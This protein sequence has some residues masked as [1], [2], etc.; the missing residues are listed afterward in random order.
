MIG[1]TFVPDSAGRVS[2]QVVGPVST[3]TGSLN[4][5]RSFHTA[6]LLPNRK[7]LV[8][9]GIRYADPWTLT[10]SAEIYDP[11]TGMWSETGSLNA[12]RYENT[13]TLLADGKVLV[14]GGV[15]RASILGESRSL[16]SA[17][18]YDSLTGTWSSTGNLN[19]ARHGHAAVLL[20][21]GKILVA[22]GYNEVRQAGLSA[23]I[24]DPLTGRWSETGA[25]N[26]LRGVYTATLLAE[27]KVLVTG[28]INDD[29]PLS[30]ELYDPIGGTWSNTGDLKMVR[31]GH[32]SALLSSGKLLV[33]D[34]DNA[35]L[36]DPVTGTWSITGNLNLPYN[37]GSYT[38]TL[39]SSGKVLAVGFFDYD[40]GYYQNT[41]LYDPTTG[42][43]SSAG[44]LITGRD[45]HTA[46]LLPN[47]RLLIAGG[48][49]YEFTLNHAELFDADLPPIG[50]IASVSA[51][52]YSPLGLASEAI[53]ASFGSGL[54]ATTS[55]ATTLPLPTELAGT[56]VKIKDIA[57]IERLAP[58]F[59]V[60]PQQ[61]N[62]QIPA[63][64][65]PGAASVI[66][67]NG[68]GVI[69]TGVALINGVAPSLFAAD[70]NGQGVAA[71][72][73]LRIKAD[74]SRVYEPVAQ[75]DAAQNRFIARP[76][77]LGPE[78]EQVFLILFGTG[79]RSRSSLA[80]VIATIGGAYADVSYAGAQ[81]DFVGLD[82]VN[83]LVPRSLVGRGEIDVLLTVEAQ[84]AN[85]VRVN[86]K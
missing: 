81:G 32:R 30:A 39:L 55:N 61:V 82:Q 40:E 21:N 24:Y 31:F 50:T 47:G 8:V 38:T 62:Y 20:P 73:A 22:G 29:V 41:K 37:Q 25:L 84:M 67:A 10:S 44:R 5:P 42:S 35:E 43:W 34:G 76:L 70:D 66:I 69:S 48:S 15:F 7:V 4:N 2:A 80:S 27:G 77:D 54:A 1:D 64:T 57:G 33:V 63:G 14:A 11:A 74:G 85:P 46:T 53:I 23:E 26:R 45:N 16:N 65:V 78:G 49:N 36:Y 13:A 12:A 28:W 86:L 19:R 56:T 52:S 18:L 17:E 75:F 9:G 79:I 83:V 60:S 51:A 72:L 6:T 59:F 68:S 71:A 58:L 3:L